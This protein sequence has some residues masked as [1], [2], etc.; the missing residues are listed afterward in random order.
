MTSKSH[1]LVEIAGIKK[2]CRKPDVLDEVINLVFAC[3]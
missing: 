3:P 1:V 2:T